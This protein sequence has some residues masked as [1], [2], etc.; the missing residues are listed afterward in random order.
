MRASIA[1]K[2]LTNVSLTLATMA[3]VARISSTPTDATVRRVI[4]TAN[5]SPKRMSASLILALMAVLASMEFTSKFIQLSFV[6]SDGV[7][8]DS[9]GESAHRAR[10]GRDTDKMSLPA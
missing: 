8:R 3:A 9:G 5:V 4:T 6:P 10:A 2:T 7:D 1:S